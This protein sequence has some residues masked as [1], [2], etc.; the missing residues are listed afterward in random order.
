[1]RSSRVAAMVVLMAVSGCA[2]CQ[3][4][5]ETDKDDT[6][7]VP[8]QGVIGLMRGERDDVTCSMERTGAAWS[9]SHVR[10]I[11]FASMDAN[12]DDS[13]GVVEVWDGNG[14]RWVRPAAIPTA[15]S[16]S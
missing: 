7:T 5:S 4:D 14:Y 10:F 12:G 3:V 6:T 11:R 15:V 1:M 9:P 8:P 2:H 13:A 16:A